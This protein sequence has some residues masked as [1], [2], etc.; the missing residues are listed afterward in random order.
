M[1]RYKF[2]FSS[3]FTFL[4]IHFTDHNYCMS[5]E[6]IRRKI[7]IKTWKVQIH[8][9]FIHF[10]IFF[11]WKLL[12]CYERKVFFMVVC[13]IIIIFFFN[14]RTAR[15]KHTNLHLWRN[16]TSAQAFYYRRCCVDVLC[17][18]LF[19]DNSTEKNLLQLSGTELHP[20]SR[21]PTPILPRSNL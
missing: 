9:F 17:V 14:L 10:I 20:S 18:L 1:Y 3:F 13:L 19:S 11:I 2:S 4:Q 15:V 16:K 6:R 8:I 21:L 12:Y 5:E 7:K